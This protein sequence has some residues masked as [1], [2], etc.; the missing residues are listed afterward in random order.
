M[1]WNLA[2][3]FFSAQR[4]QP[5]SPSKLPA[6]QLPRPLGDVGGGRSDG[7]HA[8]HHHYLRGSFSH[9]HPTAAPFGAPGPA[10]CADSR[11]T[12]ILALGAAEDLSPPHSA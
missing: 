8:G 12:S 11:R 4:E 3:A 1:P 5:S 9:L 2:G 7:G 10:V 6:Y